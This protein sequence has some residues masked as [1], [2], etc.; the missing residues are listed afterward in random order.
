MDN[1]SLP[2]LYAD[3]L[4][5]SEYEDEIE[6]DPYFKLLAL[7]RRELN[8]ATQGMKGR[9]IQA[10]KMFFEGRSRVEIGKDVSATPATISKWL[11]LPECKRVLALLARI[12]LHNEGP[13]DGQSKHMLW[14]MAQR[15]EKMDPRV[16]ISA[17]SEINKM[18]H[19]Q[20]LLAR[21]HTGDS[22]VEIV[23][24]NQALA[25]GALD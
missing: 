1:Q 25:K 10:C 20:E 11:K 13:V 17:I 4:P 6:V 15:N 5:D 8:H 22:K 12:E 24:N 18:N 23:I 9:Q 2:E 21:G 3:D 14:R 16:S 19:N 7:L